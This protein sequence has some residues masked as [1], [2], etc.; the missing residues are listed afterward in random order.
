MVELASATGT[1]LGQAKV[2]LTQQLSDVK[3][4]AS[5]PDPKEP[6]GNE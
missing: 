3:A 6:G 5:K 1:L 2:D 4:D